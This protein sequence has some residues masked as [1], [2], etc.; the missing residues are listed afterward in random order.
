MLVTHDIRINTSTDEIVK[1]KL[2]YDKIISDNLYV[3]GFIGQSCQ[4]TTLASYINYNISEFSKLR[5]EKDQIKKDNKEIRAKVENLFKTLVNLCDSSVIRSKDYTDSKQMIYRNM[6]DNKL[7]AF[8]ETCSEIQ[9]NFSKF[10]ESIN[11]KVEEMNNEVNKLLNMKNEFIDLIDNKFKEVKEIYYSLETKI[12]INVQEIDNIKENIKNLEKYNKDLELRIKDLSFKMRNYYSVNNKICKGFEAVGVNVNNQNSIIN[13]LKKVKI[14]DKMESNIGQLISA[15]QNNINPIKKAEAT[16]IP[17]KKKT[18][19]S[20]QEMIT[21]P[22]N[23]FGRNTK[24][25]QSDNKTD[26]KTFSSVKEDNTDIKTT[27][28]KNENPTRNI[29]PSKCPTKE[30]INIDPILKNHSEEI[31]D[32]IQSSPN[33]SKLEKKLEFT[34]NINNVEEKKPKLDNK[35]IPLFEKKI[36][37][38][39]SNDNIISNKTKIIHEEIRSRNYMNTSS[40]VQNNLK[41]QKKKNNNNNNTAANTYLTLQNKIQLD[42]NIKNDNDMCKIVKL[43][44]EDNLSLIDD[45]FFKSTMIKRILRK[46]KSN[47]TVKNGKLELPACSFSTVK[48]IKFKK[49]QQLFKTME[50]TGYG[51]VPKKIG[52]AFGRTVETFYFNKSP[53]TMKKD[54]EYSRD[55]NEC[56]TYRNVNN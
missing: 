20:T 28:V 54:N 23:Y 8:N 43:N 48:N 15:N 39:N 13:F 37:K 21:V 12:L 36:N 18:T 6:L 53:M 27:T 38:I 17:V 32:E 47:Y 11:L 14:V 34:Q 5:T 3:A 25:I 46:G 19:N 41:K 56:S 33:S 10:E 44:L 55:R 2:K 31:S 24:T 30:L 52:Q 49:N 16:P 35:N 7:I 50:I 51:E 26:N 9:N 29:I 4:F 42:K 22:K 40:N 1:M 45:E